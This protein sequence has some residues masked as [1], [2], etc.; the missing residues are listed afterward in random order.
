M[1]KIFLNH[2]K[3]ALSMTKPL[4]FIQA[5]TNNLYFIWILIFFY[6]MINMVKGMT[7]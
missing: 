4:I 7:F 6:V 2:R 5:S 3:Q 1:N